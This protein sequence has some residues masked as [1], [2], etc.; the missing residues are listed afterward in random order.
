MKHLP[1]ID[2]R[3]YCPQAFLSSSFHCSMYISVKKIDALC[4]LLKIVYVV[5]ACFTE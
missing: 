2:T 4:T 5:I 3:S 1:N